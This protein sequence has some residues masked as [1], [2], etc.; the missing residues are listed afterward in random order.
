MLIK[1][2]GLAVFQKR[3]QSNGSRKYF[4]DH[5]GHKLNLKGK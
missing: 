5:E 4:P 3:V 1:L 2:V